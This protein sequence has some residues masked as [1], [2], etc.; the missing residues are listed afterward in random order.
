MKFR[1]VLPFLA[2]AAAFA[3]SLPAGRGDDSAHAKADKHSGLDRFKALEGDWVGKMSEDGKNWIDATVKYTV[4]SSGSTVVETLAPGTKFEM[5]TVIHPDG[6][7]LG[8]THYCG[9]GNQPHMKAHVNGDSNTIA[10]DF[11]SAS[12][13]KSDKDMHMHNVA[14]T[15]ADKDTLRAVWTN[16]HDGKPAGTATFEFKRKK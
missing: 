15:F 2:I 4:T 16:Y 10:F 8:L 12:N 9:I 11:V 1:A 3:L 5:I 13:M 6:K 14:Y 7:D